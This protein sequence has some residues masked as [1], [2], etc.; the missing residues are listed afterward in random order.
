[1]NP[2]INSQKNRG[3]CYLAGAGPGDIG[4]VTLKTKGCV[5]DEP[6]ENYDKTN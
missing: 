4:L 2:I 5:E 1:M 3:I 6:I